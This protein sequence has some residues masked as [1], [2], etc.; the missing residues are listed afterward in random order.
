MVQ[1]LPEHTNC[2]NCSQE[3]DKLVRY[4]IFTAAAVG[5][6]RLAVVRRQFVILL[7]SFKLT[8]NVNN[9]NAC[10]AQLL[11][12]STILLCYVSKYRNLF[13]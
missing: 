3:F 8:E 10:Q 12:S 2:F 5:V 1:R 6:V 11:Q 4:H 13:L 9:C 7:L